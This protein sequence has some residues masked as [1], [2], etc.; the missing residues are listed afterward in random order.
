[1]SATKR[2]RSAARNFWLGSSGMVTGRNVC[3]AQASG[4]TN[5]AFAYR[6]DWTWG[7]R[8][9][10]SHRALRFRDRVLRLGERSLDEISRFFSY[11][12]FGVSTTPL[13]LI[14]KSSCVAAML[15]HGL[16]VIVNRDD[17]HFRGVPKAGFS[18]L[19][20]P[21]DQN[22]LERVRS[23]GGE[24]LN[25]DFPTWRNSFSAMSAHEDSVMPP[26]FFIRA[27]EGSNRSAWR[28]PENFRW[29]GTW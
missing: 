12:D 22:F 7:I 10:G 13:A 25:H 8:L 29:L 4:Q 27:W 11:L 18:E 14:G 28:W 5:S 26:I 21:V 15:D 16:P 9:D 1:M 20:I 2:Y 19:L 17:V 3:R 6:T 24:P 23:A